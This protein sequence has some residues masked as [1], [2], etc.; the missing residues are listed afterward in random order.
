MTWTNCSLICR[1]PLTKTHL[2]PTFCIR[3]CPPTLLSPAR[4]AL[5]VLDIGCSSETSPASRVSLFCSDAPFSS[6]T[7]PYERPPLLEGTCA[8][9]LVDHEPATPDSAGYCCQPM[10][11]HCSP[12]AIPTCPPMGAI[13]GIVFAMTNCM[14]SS[15]EG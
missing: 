12:C 6:R 10:E 1:Y 3:P 2:S 11:P 13:A 5:S 15:A 8:S 4:P 9:V 14:I 7:L